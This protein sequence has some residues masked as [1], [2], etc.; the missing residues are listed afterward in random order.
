MV[1]VAPPSGLATIYIITTPGFTGG[2]KC[3]DPL[4]LAVQPPHTV[5]DKNFFNAI[6]AQFE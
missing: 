6:M 4:G 2:Y 5:S 1:L 3:F